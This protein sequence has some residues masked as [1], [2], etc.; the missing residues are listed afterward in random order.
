MLNKILSII[1]LV[2]I[3]NTILLA[4]KNPKLSEIIPV[5]SQV[6]HKTL[7]NG[8]SYYL[9]QNA[10][11]EHTCLI[12]LLIKVGSLSEEDNEQGIAHFVE[13]LA[14]N[15]T[16][17]FPKRKI[18][19][20]LEAMGMKFGA[21]INAHTAWDRTA[22]E[23]EV[24]TK[25]P[26][27]L[28]KGLEI[29]KDWAFNISFEKEEVEKEKGVVLSERR[30]RKSASEKFQKQTMDFSF[31]SSRHTK[32]YPIGDSLTIQNATPALLQNFYK[33]WYRPDLM[34][35]V[36]V[37][38]FKN[39]AD[40]EQKIIALFS[41]AQNPSS[42][43]PLLTYAIPPLDTF[44]TLIIKD[45]E[46]PYFWLSYSN[47]H[48]FKKDS[49][50][51]EMRDNL[52]TTIANS[53]IN[54]YLYEEN[55]KAN[56]PFLGCSFSPYAV[57]ETQ[58][59][60]SIGVSLR[61]KDILSGIKAMFIERKKLMQYQFPNE[62]L[63]QIKDYFLKSFKLQMQEYNNTRNTEW[64]NA[65]VTLAFE[66]RNV[67]DT[68]SYMALQEKLV[69]SISIEE[70]NEV[71]QKMFSPK[72]GATLIYYG[73][74]KDGVETPSETQLFKI[75]QE[76]ENESV[77]KI[78]N[79]QSSK[80]IITKVPT[81]VAFLSKK[82]EP[83]TEENA[84][85]AALWMTTYRYP[86]GAKV[87]VLPTK[88]KED[89]ILFSAYSEGGTSNVS[90]EEHFNAA[91]AARI[92]G[93]S[94]IA[95]LTPTEFRELGFGKF[96]S[97]KPSISNSY[98]KIEGSFVSKDAEFFFQN[99]YA[100]HVFPRKDSN[101][102]EKFIVS[103][104]QNIINRPL[105]PTYAFYDTLY[106][107]KSGFDPMAKR[108]T[109]AQIEQLRLDKMLDFYKEKFQS[110]GGFTYFFVGNTEIIPD[111]EQNINTYIGSLPARK[112]K[113]KKIISAYTT[114]KGQYRLE[115]ADATDT[116]NTVEIYLTGKQKDSRKNRQQLGMLA[117]VLESKL[118]IELREEKSA[119]YGVNANG[120]I[121]D[122]YF[123]VTVN[124]NCEPGKEEELIKAT[125]AIF[126]KIKTEG[127]TPEELTKIVE[128]RK[129]THDE[130]RKNNN[131][132]LY[133]LQSTYQKGI[134]L[135]F[136]KTADLAN[137]HYYDMKPKDF[138]ALAKHY[139]SRENEIVSILKVKEN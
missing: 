89:E 62:K 84:T 80:K 94:G 34:R 121:D 9:K 12:Q 69:A 68:K 135:D 106:A 118:L 126:D 97:V 82:T 18:V 91:Y 88:F 4:Q 17:N 32:R 93:S 65:L 131:S 56:P 24:P 28:Y 60:M 137:K 105:L 43:K 19:E 86:N 61:E 13:H 3:A 46:A 14:F 92:I 134:S 110:G 5:D 37:G 119:V 90:L 138:A 22:Y 49:S 73:M 81:P 64:A 70:V 25:T 42:E 100:V 71:I 39:I 133:T 72:K 114:P 136:M 102:F 10:K 75:M 74:D 63:A 26:E 76:V 130:S 23:I 96:S 113:E 112:S 111:F 16:K 31:N 36:V 1:F 47:R 35:L 77:V 108:I 29:A 83:L 123:Y 79:T 48:F 87:V 33:T 122:D 52:I 15:G 125:Y 40:I 95:D 128:N 129:K 98:K 103:E 139:L 11:P 101:V 45:K 115:K 127:A 116:K 8:F 20:E 6:I 53:L 41:E 117:E 120:Y 54:R 55:Q 107:L 109:L 78:V 38:D 2:F 21:D 104:K 30:T 44:K 57:D 124:F 27:T 7:P 99:L 66:N 67:L 132:L 58:T 51:R 85:D 50:L 59:D